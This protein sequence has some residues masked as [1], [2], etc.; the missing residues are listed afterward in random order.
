M[1]GAQPARPS[2]VIIFIEQGYLISD[3]PEG[4]EV[5]YVMVG[6]KWAGQTLYL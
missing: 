1:W 6:S 5:V 3:V 4:V 2:R